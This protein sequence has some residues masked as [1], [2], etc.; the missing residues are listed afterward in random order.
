MRELTGL[1]GRDELVLQIA[2]EVRKGRHVLLTGPA[3]L[4][5]SAVLEAVIARIERRGAAGEAE[6]TDPAEP[7]PWRDSRANRRRLVIHIVEHQTKAQFVA[8]ARR[9]LEAGLVKPSA[10]ELARSYDAMDPREIEWARIK[11][12]VNRLSIRDLAEAIIPAIHGYEGRVI[13]AVD[14]LTGLTPTLV[15]FWL[16]VLDSA[17]FLGCATEKRKNLAKLWWKMTTIEV[18]P[19]SPQAARDIVQGYIR[20]AGLLIEAPDLFINHVVQQANGN[21]RAMADMLTDSSKERVV[22][23]RRIREMKHA[24]GVRY[25]DFTPVVMIGTACIIGARYLAMG[26]GDKALY[27]VAGMLAAVI[28]SVRFLLFR[29]AGKAD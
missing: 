26:T 5:K 12:N 27:I 16:S 13:I 4:G 21:P 25:L 15:A 28:V 6:E 8:I 2:R 7:A 18:P 1:I 11:R 10:L 29:G 24:A 14:D 9:L 3:G 23:K 20:G 19:L 22:D 17:Q